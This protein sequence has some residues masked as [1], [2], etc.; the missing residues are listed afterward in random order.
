MWGCKYEFMK[1]VD[2]ENGRTGMDANVRGE[3]KMRFWWVG[4]VDGWVGW[5]VGKKMRESNIK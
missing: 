4:W 1:K 5:W 3:S 2:I